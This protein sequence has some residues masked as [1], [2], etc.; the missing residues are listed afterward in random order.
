MVNRLTQL[1]KCISQE[2]LKILACLSMLL[3]HTGAILV[4]SLFHHASASGQDTRPILELYDLLRTLGRLAFPIYCFLLC[5]GVH[6]T[7]H[8]GRYGLRLLIAAFLSELPFDLALHGGFS[9]Q[10]QSVMVTLLLGFLALESMK[11]CNLLLPKLLI[12][13][14]FAILA[15]ILNTDYGAD[16]IWLMSIFFLTRDLPYGRAL[17][18][19]GM[20]FLFSPGNRMFLNWQY[21]ISITTQEWA[22]LSLIPISLYSGEKHF[23]SKGLQWAFYLFYPVH[24][25]ALW[26]LKGALYG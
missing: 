18:F 15:E 1:P 20:W 7:H 5:E 23:R 9:W 4:F 6:H 22:V 14:P 12:I 21:G 8:P 10:N 26:I 11:R 19:L 3:D 25:T 2:G 16:G 24:L 17:Q 13:L